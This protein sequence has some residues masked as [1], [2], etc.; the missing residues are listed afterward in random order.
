MDRL[1]YSPITPVINLDHQDPILGITNR[2]K[3]FFT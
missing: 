3:N 1:Q 2:P